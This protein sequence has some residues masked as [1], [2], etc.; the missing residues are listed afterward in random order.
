MLFE[1]EESIN[2]VNFIKINIEGAEMSFLIGAENS[3]KQ[4]RPLIAIELIEEHLNRF[5][6]NIKEVVNKIVSYEYKLFH[7]NNSNDF[8]A[9][10]NESID[11][12]LDDLNK[13]TIEV[14]W[15]T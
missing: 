4:F 10:P 3:I 1:R 5:E 2:Q 11:I 7:I 15:K 6:T 9:I 13:F 8:F 12:Y 14:K